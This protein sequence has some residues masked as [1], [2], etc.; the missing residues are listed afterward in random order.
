MNGNSFPYFP[1]RD[2]LHVHDILSV[3]FIIGLHFGLC[4]RSLSAFFCGQALH[5]LL[6]QVI[7]GRFLRFKLFNGRTFSF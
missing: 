5:Q 1:G 2:S 4:H 7:A 6:V 3:Q